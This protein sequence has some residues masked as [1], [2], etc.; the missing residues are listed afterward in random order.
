MSITNGDV[1]YTDL[2]SDDKI[3]PYTAGCPH[4]T[5]YISIGPVKMDKLKII[6][7]RSFSD[8][9]V[10]ND[11]IAEAINDQYSF[12]LFAGWCKDPN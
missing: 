4:T 12:D 10:L 6:S 9:T 2:Q 7:R 8:L 3:Q 11:F 1:R 5:R